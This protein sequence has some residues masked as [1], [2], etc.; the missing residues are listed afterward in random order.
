MPSNRDRLIGRMPVLAR[1]VQDGTPEHLGREAGPS[2][3]FYSC[4][5]WKS[6]QLVREATPGKIRAKRSSCQYQKVHLC[7]PKAE[8]PHVL[9]PLAN[10]TLLLADGCKISS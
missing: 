7:F 6:L 2:L 3:T 9:P 5:V 8:S 10:C 4:S 1:E